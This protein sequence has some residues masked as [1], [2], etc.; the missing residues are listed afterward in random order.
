MERRQVYVDDITDTRGAADILGLAQS[1]T[2]H[3]YRR[4]YPDFPQP[5]LNLGAGRCILWLR[6]DLLAWREAHPARTR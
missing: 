3:K 2:V 1:D 6:T 5:L 4:N